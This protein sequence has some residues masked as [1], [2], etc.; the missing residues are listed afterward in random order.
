MCLQ[1]KTSSR[2]HQRL[3]KCHIMFAVQFQYPRVQV[4]PNEPV[5]QLDLYDEIG[6]LKVLHTV[7]INVQLE[8]PKCAFFNM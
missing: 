2:I 7:L 8:T 6:Q 1:K 3:I 5:D 4:R